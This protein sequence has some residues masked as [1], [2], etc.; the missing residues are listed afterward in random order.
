V[1]T[2]SGQE[3]TRRLLCGLFSVAFTALTLSKSYHAYV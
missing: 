3:K 2:L 1:V